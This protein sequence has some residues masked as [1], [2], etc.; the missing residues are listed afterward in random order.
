MCCN[1]DN[2]IKSLILSSN[3]Y[4]N[5]I[6]DFTIL[7]NNSFILNAYCST[8]GTRINLTVSWDK[9]PINNC[10]GCVNNI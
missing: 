7:S 10:I 6:S 1:T 4:A 2:S 8:E 5:L 9:L 3:E